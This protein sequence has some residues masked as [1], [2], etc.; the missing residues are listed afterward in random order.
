LMLGF[1][2]GVFARSVYQRRVTKPLGNV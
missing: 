2:G 1:V